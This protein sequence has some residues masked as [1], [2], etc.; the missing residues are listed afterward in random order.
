MIGLKPRGALAIVVLV[1]LSACTVADT[2]GLDPSDRAAIT[3][4]LTIDPQS[5]PNY[6]G[7][8]LPA[9]YTSPVLTREDGTIAR[10]ITNA[11]ATLGRV[12][13]YDRNLS[14]N[15]TVSCATCHAQGR[16]FADTARF[17]LGFEGVG[18]TGAHSMRLTNA[19]FNENGRFFWDR[20]AATL[21]A[22]TTEPIQNSVEMGFDAA[23][24]GLNAVISTISGLAYYP[25]LFTL[26]YGDASI[27]TDRIQRALAQYVRSIVSTRSRWDLAYVSVFQP[28]DPQGSLV[29]PLPGFTT[30]ESRGQT[31]FI[32]PPQN[33]GLGCA[34]CHVPPTY[35]LAGNSRSNGLDS[36]ETTIFRSPSL[37]NVALSAHFMHDGRFSSIEEVVEFYN[38]GVQAGPALDQRLTSAP[39]MPRRLN[40]SV[41][42]KAALAAF[43]RTL[44]EQTVGVDAK[45][46]DPFRR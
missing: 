18:R 40:M 43:L 10:P 26:A 34:G 23:H 16:A 42:E 4:A 19:R 11:G 2:S 9:Y 36:L 12:L 45:F 21:E 3:A 38:S 6:A 22:Q 25:P 29:S 5:L 37:K 27:T 41:S 20:R 35:S 1:F 7:Q 39:G 31:L 8:A 30:A 24:G 28:N 44:S 46:S 15:N 32:Q 17:S 33:G 13:Y 14:V